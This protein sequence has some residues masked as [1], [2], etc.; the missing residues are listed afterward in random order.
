MNELHFSYVFM[1]GDLIRYKDDTTYV[2]YRCILAGIMQ[3]IFNLLAPEL[4][5]SF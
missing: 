3:R 2:V 1:A 5:F 4:F